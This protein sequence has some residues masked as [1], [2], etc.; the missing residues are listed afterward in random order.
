MDLVCEVLAL[1]LDPHPRAPGADIA[2]L[3]TTRKRTRS[4]QA[5]RRARRNEG[6]GRMRVRDRKS[7]R[8]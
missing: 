7:P 3:D 4:R 8:C 1:G 5:L 6:T 2:E